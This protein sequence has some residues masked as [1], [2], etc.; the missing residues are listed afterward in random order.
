MI[1]KGGD[2]D[3][4][5]R[6]IVYNGVHF[7]RIRNFKD[8][9]KGFLDAIATFTANEIFNYERLVYYTIISSVVS[10]DR[11]SIR[12]KLID[13]PEIIQIID[14]LPVLK[15]FLHSF[16][17]CRYNEFFRSLIELMKDFVK[18][19]YYLHLHSAY[20]MRLIR[21]RA[22]SQFLESYQSVKIS[23][24]AKA[25]GVSEEFLDCELSSFISNPNALIT[26][27]I[28]KVN[29]IVEIHRTNQRNSQYHEV[30]KRGDALLGRIQRLSRVVTY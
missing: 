9:A 13:S 28:D 8:A 4:R 29:G 25:F 7:F 27:K 21:V 30:I 26:C 11:V 18:K 6:F 12:E 24:M 1:D 3:R 14:T 22:Y 2:W 19:D 20:Y 10:L 5:N 16:Y 17:Y 23:T 15:S